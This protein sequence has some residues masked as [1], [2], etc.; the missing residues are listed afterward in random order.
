MNKQSVE[1]RGRKGNLELRRLQNR[2]NRADYLKMNKHLHK[3]EEKKANIL[4]IVRIP[5]VTK[6]RRWGGE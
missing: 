4:G 5:S 6:K 3:Q 1:G 2:V